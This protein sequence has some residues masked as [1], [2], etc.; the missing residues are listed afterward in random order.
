MKS[1]QTV[2][3]LNGKVNYMNKILIVKR[4]P[5]LGNGS[6]RREKGGGLSVKS[7][8]EIRKDFCPNILQIFLKTLIEGDV[9][10]E[11]GI[12]FQYLTTLTEYTDPLLRR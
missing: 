11:A 1:V 9:S 12:L 3:S 2:H 7:M 5:K 6:G 10:K 8:R 4:W